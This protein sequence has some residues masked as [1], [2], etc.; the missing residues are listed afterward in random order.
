MTEKFKLTLTTKHTFECHLI[1]KRAQR[2]RE[3]QIIC[4]FYS[5]RSHIKN[6]T[7]RLCYIREGKII[8]IHI[9]ER[10][11]KSDIRLARKNKAPK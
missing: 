8:D 9:G 4:S 10:K 3:R 7:I 1:H 2:D 6:I 11:Q 5:S